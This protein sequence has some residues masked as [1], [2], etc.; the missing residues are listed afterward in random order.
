MKGCRR[1]LTPS[2]AALL[3]SGAVKHFLKSATAKLPYAFRIDIA[4]D[5]IATSGLRRQQCGAA[6]SEWINNQISGLAQALNDGLEG[7]K[8]LPRA[9]SLFGGIVVAWADEIVK[10]LLCATV[11][12]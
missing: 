12:Y 6:A 10:M 11:D 7:V 3:P 8:A 5:G 9:M 4:A 1:W 2:L